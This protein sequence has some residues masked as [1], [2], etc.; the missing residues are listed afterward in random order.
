MLAQSRDSFYRFKELYANGG[1]QALMDMS[2]KKPILKNR[3]SEHDEKAVVDLAIE[4]PALGQKRASWEVQQHGIM[5]SS[6]GVR[7]VWLRHDPGI[8]PRSLMM[9]GTRRAVKTLSCS[10][11]VCVEPS[12][13]AGCR[14]LQ[15]SRL[16]HG[17]T[18]LLL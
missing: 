2:R 5:I 12:H 11:C 8:Y 14:L 15:S 4:N 9:S 1:E 3:V 7:S 17:R 13:Q 18:A 10:S 16:R 6:S